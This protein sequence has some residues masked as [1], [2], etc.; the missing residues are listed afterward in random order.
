MSDED[1]TEILVNVATITHKL[2][3]EH[4]LKT[5]NGDTLSY[6]AVKLASL[7]ASLID[8]KVAAHSDALK[9]EIEADRQ[10]A[11]AYKKA[12]KETNATAAKDGK[13]DDPDYI[14]AREAFADA[15]VKFE[16][17][18]SITADAHDVIESIRSRVIDLQSQRKD[19]QV[20]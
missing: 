20:K 3:D 17:L 7:K 15:K 12:L 2:S 18:K 4:F 14:K 5:L 10:K 19:E 1:L 9:K 16:K 8:M 6:T 13:Y 11:I